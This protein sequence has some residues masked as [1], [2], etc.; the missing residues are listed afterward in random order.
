MIFLDAFT[1]N[2]VILLIESPCLLVRWSV[3]LK[4]DH[5]Y[6]Y[7]AYIHVCTRVKDRD[8]GYVVVHHTYLYHARIQVVRRYIHHTIIHHT[9]HALDDM[10]VPNASQSQSQGQVDPFRDLSRGLNLRFTNVSI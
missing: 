6:M 3:E 10:G 2:H 5:S 8:H 4:L 9:I 1:S 7:H